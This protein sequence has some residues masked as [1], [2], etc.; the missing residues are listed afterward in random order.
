MNKN[1][2]T[3]TDYISSLSLSDAATDTDYIRAAEHMYDTPMSREREISGLTE[4]AVVI[5]G[6][7]DSSQRSMKA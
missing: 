6:V 4:T 3:D 5:K 1:A 2:A 7:L